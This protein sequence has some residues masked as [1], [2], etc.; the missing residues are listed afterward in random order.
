MHFEVVVCWQES[1]EREKAISMASALAAFAYGLSV[2]D[3]EQDKK[4]N[5]R[6]EEDEEYVLESEDE[7]QQQ[8]EEEV[9]MQNNPATLLDFAKQQQKATSLLQVAQQESEWE[10]AASSQKLVKLANQLNQEDAAANKQRSAVVQSALQAT[11]EQVRADFQAKRQKE[12]AQAVQQAIVEEQQYQ[13]DEFEEEDPAIQRAA[14]L[15]IAKA[16]AAAADN[17]NN[18]EHPSQKPSSA[19]ALSVD[20]HVLKQR[21][22]RHGLHSKST[23][24]AKTMKDRLST[25]QFSQLSITQRRVFLA[26]LTGDAEKEATRRRKQCNMVSSE[27][28]RWLCVLD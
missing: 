8:E 26:T 2:K 23:T 4:Q 21:Q 9:V 25:F 24:K 17:T 27:S 16:T 1:R 10:R 14:N 15:L 13:L 19:L 22:D 5:A 28:A 11:S 18:G 7:E 3:S 12:V 20:R 6:K